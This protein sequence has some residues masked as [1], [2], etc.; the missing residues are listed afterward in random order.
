MLKY[1]YKKT[2]SKVKKVSLVNNL[3]L[4]LNL[5]VF[6]ILNQGISYHANHYKIRNCF[7]IIIVI[8][9]QYSIGHQKKEAKN[10]R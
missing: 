8:I 3:K 7:R 4:T 9:W 5:N 1:K 2:Y 10:P 6:N